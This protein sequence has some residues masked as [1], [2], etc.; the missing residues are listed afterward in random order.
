LKNNRVAL[1]DL[2]VLLARSSNI[3]E[4]LRY[5]EEVKKLSS[6]SFISYFNKNWH[7]T[8]QE[9]VLFL[10]AQFTMGNNTNNR[11][12]SFHDKVKQLVDARSPIDEL[13]RALILLCHCVD[14]EMGFQLSQ[15]A[16][17]TFHHSDSEMVPFLGV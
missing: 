8:R 10:S 15:T 14:H 17:K 11:L 2:F 3:E 9:W 16:L 12:E 6:A 4:Y 5:Y 7:E 1:R 13:L